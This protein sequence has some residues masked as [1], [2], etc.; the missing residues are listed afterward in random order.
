MILLFSQNS[1]VFIALTNLGAGPRFGFWDRPLWG[2]VN[3]GVDPRHTIE[4]PHDS[5]RWI[6]MRFRGCDIIR[7]MFCWEYRHAKIRHRT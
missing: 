3:C 6:A 4:Q 1:V 7:L 5:K 2:S